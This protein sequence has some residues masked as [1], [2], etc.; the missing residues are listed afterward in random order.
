MPPLD[1]L[2]AQALV[3]GP[4]SAPL[5]IG[6]LLWYLFATGAR[7]VRTL[8]FAY[9]LITAFFLTRHAKV[10]YL[11]PVYPMLFAAGG[12]ALE[13]WLARARA[14]WAWGVYAVALSAAGV[15][16]VPLAVP[17]LPVEQQ[18]A[19][20][21]KAGIGE[22]RTERHREARLPQTMADM[23]G[24]EEMVADVSRVYHA[25][26]AAEQ[27]RCAIYANNYGQAGAIDFLGKR[28]GLPDAVSGHNSY[29]MWGAGD[30]TRG[31]V[32]ICVGED[33]SDVAETYREVT[34]QTHHPSPYAMPFEMD[35]PIVVGRRPKFTLREVWKS[36]KHYI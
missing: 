15:L 4:L 7:R 35:A 18:I 26:P 24:W 32:V 14:R 10:Y 21:R 1:F 13:E 29:W 3:L 6:G 20:I 5:W 8:G 19:Y 22:I 17:V 9:L 34:V 31:D 25:L 30:G 33:S 27:K 2:K 36:C 11:T 16:A 23:F 28:Y 12:V